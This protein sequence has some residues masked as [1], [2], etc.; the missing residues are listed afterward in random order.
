M[1]I[2]DKEEKFGLTSLIRRAVGYGGKTTADYIRSLYIAYGSNGELETLILL[3]GDLVS[4]DS[5]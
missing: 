5:P 3:S 2:R 1:R 4:I